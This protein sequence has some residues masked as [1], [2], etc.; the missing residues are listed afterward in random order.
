[1]LASFRLAFI[2]GL[3]I[4]FVSFLNKTLGGCLLRSG[5]QVIS[6]LL[7]LKKS[8]G[9]RKEGQH[10][11]R[12]TLL[13]CGGGKDTS[14]VFDSIIC[15][16][17]FKKRNF[18]LQILGF[19]FTNTALLKTSV[20]WALHKALEHRGEKWQDSSVALFWPLLSICSAPSVFSGGYTLS[21]M[22]KRDFCLKLLDQE[23]DLKYLHLR[24]RFLRGS[25]TRR[26]LC[27]KISM[28]VHPSH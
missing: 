12:H 1:M 16:T 19:P 25:W 26:L 18:W 5:R 8:K 20:T 21:L 11:K 17:S 6:L 15:F 4:V 23:K 3:T 10:I 13:I 28:E 14:I 27:A 9:T 7:L 24:W 22:R 2:L